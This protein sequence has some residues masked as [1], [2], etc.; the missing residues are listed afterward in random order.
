MVLIMKVRLHNLD[1]DYF[2]LAGP[3][4]LSSIRD[5]QLYKVLLVNVMCHLAGTPWAA[6]LSYNKMAADSEG[7]ILWPHPSLEAWRWNCNPHMPKKG[8]FHGCL[9]FVTTPF[10]H[11]LY[12]NVVIIMMRLNDV[13]LLGYFGIFNDVSM[14]TWCAALFFISDTVLS[15]ISTIMCSGSKNNRNDAFSENLI[16]YFRQRQ[17]RRVNIASSILLRLPHLKRPA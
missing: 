9:K 12:Y 4:A 10:S 17:P 15:N 6:L 5:T 1:G 16:R 2:R 11:H 3:S 8:R 13:F 14:T 7:T